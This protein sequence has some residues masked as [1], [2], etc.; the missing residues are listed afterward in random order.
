ML[1]LA[2]AACEDVELAEAGIATLEDC[3]DSVSVEKVIVYRGE[4]Y[5]FCA[6]V[7]ENG[8]AVPGAGISAYGEDIMTRKETVTDSTGFFVLMGAA[9]VEEPSK[10]HDLL[11]N[12]STATCENVRI[13]QPILL[14]SVCR[15]LPPS[16]IKVNPD[17]VERGDLFEVYI[18]GV[19]KK[20]ELVLGFSAGYEVRE[21]LEEGISWQQTYGSN[22]CCNPTG[23]EEEGC[24]CELSFEFT[25][26]RHPLCVSSGNV[27]KVSVVG[28]KPVPMKPL[29]EFPFIFLV[30]LIPLFAFRIHTKVI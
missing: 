28:E 27:V 19:P 23:E 4:V 10:Y 26:A 20:M 8:K 3:S 14:K 13:T 6:R 22:T 15:Q 1:S 2:F 12:V 25:D 30:V 17:R 21:T 9:V 29:P 11:V 7:L 24:E 5:Y 16:T 18:S